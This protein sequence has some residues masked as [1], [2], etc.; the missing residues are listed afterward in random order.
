MTVSVPLYIKPSIIIHA[1]TPSKPTYCSCLS[2]AALAPATTTKAMLGHKK[3][4]WKNHGCNFRLLCT[5]YA[6]TSSMPNLLYREQTSANSHWHEME[7]LSHHWLRKA[8]K[9]LDMRQHDAC[10]VCRGQL[11]WLWTNASEVLQSSFATER[12]AGTGMARW[13]AAIA[14][15]ITNRLSD[16]KSVVSAVPWPPM[17]NHHSRLAF[18]EFDQKN[19]STV[20][21]LF[22]SFSCLCPQVVINRVKLGF[23]IDQLWI[24]WSGW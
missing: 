1:R 23:N 10:R 5:L 14:G 16:L 12:G 4:T 7:F 15:A 13:N 8:T 3:W 21:N 19:Y 2:L 17:R 11:C 24:C 6:G 22:V 9:K 20:N 18:L